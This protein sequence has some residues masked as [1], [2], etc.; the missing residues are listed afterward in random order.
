LKSL[1]GDT[2]ALGKL[3]TTMNDRL[4]TADMPG[5]E[6]AWQAT[7]LQKAIGG[8][9]ILLKKLEADINVHLDGTP[10]D[11]IHTSA[12]FNGIV[13][14]AFVPIE[15]SVA[16]V[17]QTL[18]AP[19]TIP[20]K[21][22]FMQDVERTIREDFNPRPEQIKGNY[23]QLAQ[24]LIDNPNQ[25]QDVKGAIFNNIDEKTLIRL[26]ADVPTR[27]LS[28]AHIILTEDF[29]E[30]AQ[31][32]EVEAQHNTKLYDLALNL[33]PEGRNRLW[34]FS[35]KGN[36]GAQLLVINKDGVAI[37]APRIRHELAQSSVSITQLPEKGLAQETADFLNKRETK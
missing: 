8:D 29:I 17:R 14:H 11:Q 7:D 9:P 28:N 3:V 4:R 23:L 18:K 13:I 21:A 26:Y 25:K 19:I 37:A 30:S 36:I 27:I 34:Q 20:F 15:V 22:N 35:R 32:S 5:T 16:G 6:I 2:D 1:Q 10:L 24:K 33:T 12:L 31:L